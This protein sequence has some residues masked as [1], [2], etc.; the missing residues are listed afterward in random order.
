MRCVACQQVVYETSRK[1]NKECI[2]L[3]DIN[4]LEPSD[5][6]EEGGASCRGAEAG[7][8]A[9]AA[10][11]KW[12]KKHFYPL[13]GRAKTSIEG[14]LGEGTLENSVI[15]RALAA[16]LVDKFGGHFGPAESSDLENALRDEM[17]EQ[18]KEGLPIPTVPLQYPRDGDD[19]I[20]LLLFCHQVVPKLMQEVLTKRMKDVAV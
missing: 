5:D 6:E 1:T 4:W 16:G 2:A 10:I 15:F 17:A 3:D 11:R 13:L 18:E 20:N 9:Q 8:R 19:I 12:Y 7:M 14:L